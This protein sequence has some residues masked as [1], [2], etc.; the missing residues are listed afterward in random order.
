LTRN[1]PEARRLLEPAAMA[2]H[3]EAMGAYGFMLARGLG[4]ASDP[5][6][7]YALIERAAQ[8]GV[9]SALLNQGIMTLRG[10][11]TAAD[12]PAGLALI[13]RAAERGHVEAQV[14]LAEAYFFGENDQVPRSEE[15]AA[16][17]ALKAAA[18][19]NVWAQ[20]LEGT[21]KEDGLGMA[22]DP[23]GAVESYRRAA[24]RGH[25]KAQSSLGRMLYNGPDV[26][27]DRAEAY[28]WLK[29]S[30]EQG[31]V[32]ALKFLEQVRDGFTVEEREAGEKRL[33]E[34]PPTKTAADAS[35]RRG[36]GPPVPRD[37]GT[38]ARGRK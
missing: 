32:T 30:A 1:L 37:S 35:S 18:A 3:P 21:L 11:G 24:V 2:G 28:Y 33:R 9:L 20:N 34:S 7:G 27:T 13:T 16:K 29:A 15:S 36:P 5:S 6:A 25:A 38:A 23:Q 4:V 22:R 14:W 19:G 26:A 8:A 17:W 31:E 12:G 10:Q